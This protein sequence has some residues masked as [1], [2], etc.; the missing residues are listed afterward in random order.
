MLEPVSFA[1]AETELGVFLDQLESLGAPV[2]G[3]EQFLPFKKAVH[4]VRIDHEDLDRMSRLVRA[5]LEGE[6][7]EVLEASD[8]SEAVS[9]FLERRHDIRLVV[10][11]LTMPRMHGDEALAAI[12]A[13]GGEL[14]A[15]LM[16]GYSEGEAAARFEALGLRAILK[17][18]F[19]RAD[20]LETVRAAL[21]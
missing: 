7:H 19:L 10:T 17:K 15:V 8:G 12:R 4:T 14:P 3:V 6:G 21:S 1:G 18:P 13:A 16:T 5:A 11:D 2:R 20:L 9:L